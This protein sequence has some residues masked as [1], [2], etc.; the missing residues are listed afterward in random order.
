MV[1]LAAMADRMEEGAEAVVREPR[2]VE[3]EAQ[4]EREALGV[5]ERSTFCAG[6]PKSSVKFACHRFFYEVQWFED[7]LRCQGPLT[8]HAIKILSS[9]L[10]IWSLVMMLQGV[11]EAR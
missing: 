2:L 3:Q 4:V 6:E 1:P 11:P 5:W 7:Y 9:Q 8:A 10:V